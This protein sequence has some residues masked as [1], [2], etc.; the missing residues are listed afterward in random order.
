METRGVLVG[1]T[2]GEAAD[3]DVVKS[4]ASAD[5]DQDD[6]VGPQV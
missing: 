4:E 3:R 2:E 5:V 1:D 6:E